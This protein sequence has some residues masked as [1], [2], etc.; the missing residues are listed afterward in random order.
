MGAAMETQAAH[1]LVGVASGFGRYLIGRDIGAEIRRKHF[2]GPPA[3]WPAGLDLAGVEQATESCVDELLGTLARDHGLS[4]VR[5]LQIV[6]ASPAVKETVDYVM[7]IVASPPS[8]LSPKSVQELLAQRASRKV[9]RPGR[10]S[11]RRR[12]R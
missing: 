11:S 6:G 12:S 1:S 9:G 10:R 4:S 5:A 8:P 7:S 3:S 2:A